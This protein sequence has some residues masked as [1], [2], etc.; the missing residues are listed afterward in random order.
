MKL[1]VIIPVYNEKD[2]I[3]E[4]VHR[5]KNVPL[6][7]ELIIVDDFS[8]DG[9]QEILFSMRDEQVKVL[10]HS[11]NK[12][13]G[14]CIQTALREVSGDYVIIQDAD[15][16]YNP[17]EYIQLTGPIL[18][19]EA[20]VVYG[21]RFL[22]QIP[23]KEFRLFQYIANRF[24]TILTNMLFNAKLTDMETCYKLFKA[25]LIKSLKIESNGFD[26]EPELTAKVLKRK[27][28]IVEVPISY[29]GR[30]N[31]EGKKIRP[32]DGLLSTYTLLKYKIKR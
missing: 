10:H 32:S 6:D 1:S 13:K 2:F 17:Q 31:Q 19:K 29:T 9:T 11:V 26:I 24:L 15:L 28:P 14:A 8:S 23:R 22:G 18:R 16:E 5:V 7:K 12:G 25:D 21:S 4:I 27:I 3:I 30:S 20:D